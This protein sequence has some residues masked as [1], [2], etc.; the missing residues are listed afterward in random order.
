MDC[1]DSG[2]YRRKGI[3]PYH[4]IIRVPHMDLRD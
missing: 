4:Q 2:G 1:Y 3:Y